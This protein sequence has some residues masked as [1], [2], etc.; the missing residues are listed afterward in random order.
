MQQ[1]LHVLKI[2]RE[3]GWEAAE[4][5]EMSEVTPSMI[6]NTQCDL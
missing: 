4:M 5:G 3:A 2:F 6:Y 1:H